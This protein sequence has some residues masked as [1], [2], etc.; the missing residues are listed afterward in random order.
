M[1]E[2]TKGEL[3]PYL[4]PEICRLLGHGM[5]LCDQHVI[6]VADTSDQGAGLSNL[7]TR[8]GRNVGAGKE[9]VFAFHNQK[10]FGKIN[11]VSLVASPIHGKR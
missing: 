7:V 9:P 5:N 3:S 4:H 10:G 8:R 11:A 6:M 1:K 2:E